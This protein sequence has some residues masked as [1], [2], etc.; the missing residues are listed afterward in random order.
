MKKRE[1]SSQPEVREGMS[2]HI[3]EPPKEKR[4]NISFWLSVASGKEKVY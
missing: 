3:I 4:L 1:E 2:R